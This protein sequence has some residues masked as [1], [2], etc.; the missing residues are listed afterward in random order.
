MLLGQGFESD[1]HRLNK[2][3]KSQKFIAGSIFGDII[4][5]P[6]DR[7]VSKQIENFSHSDYYLNGNRRF[8][9]KWQSQRM[10]RNQGLDK[11]DEESNTINANEPL[12]KLAIQSGAGTGYNDYN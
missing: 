5:K 12:G 10:I 8:S 6:Y 7:Q 2:K 1:G 11:N 3:S 4:E 9:K